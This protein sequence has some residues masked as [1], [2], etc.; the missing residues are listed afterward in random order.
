MTKD[1]KLSAIKQGF[2]GDIFGAGSVKHKIF[3]KATGE[4]SC[5]KW[6]GCCFGCH[7]SD[8]TIDLFTIERD[9]NLSVKLL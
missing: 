7:M 4:E 5:L 1:Q 9:D 3:N 6:I 8:N 2:I